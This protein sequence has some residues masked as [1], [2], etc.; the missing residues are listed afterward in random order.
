LFFE[1]VSTARQW[2]HVI[3]NVVNFY[4]DASRTHAQKEIVR[5]AGRQT[6]EANEQVLGYIR[7]ALGGSSAVV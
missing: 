7:A 1:V 4:L 6:R 5:L 2:S 3:A